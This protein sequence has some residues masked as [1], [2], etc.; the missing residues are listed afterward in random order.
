MLTPPPP[1]STWSSRR[2]RSMYSAATSIRRFSP[3]GTPVS[4]SGSP[5]SSPQPVSSTPSGIAISSILRSTISV[6]LPSAAMSVLLVVSFVRAPVD[7]RL[8]RAAATPPLRP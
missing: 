5:V 7:R 3:P 1:A 2:P 4:S 6:L 8:W